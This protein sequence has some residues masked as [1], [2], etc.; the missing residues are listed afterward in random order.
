MS[1]QRPSK[2]VPAYPGGTSTLADWLVGK[3]ELDSRPRSP[4]AMKTGLDINTFKLRLDPR[5]EK[6]TRSTL[7]TSSHLNQEKD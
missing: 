2:V 7:P 4:I 5:I 1:H 3:N 6:H